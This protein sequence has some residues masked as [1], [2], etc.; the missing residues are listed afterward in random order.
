MNRALSIIV[1]GAVASG[2]ATT[3]SLQYDHSRCYRESMAHQSN[4]SRPTSIGAASRCPG[5]APV[6]IGGWL[7]LSMGV[8]CG[9]VVRH[10]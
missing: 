9:R 1:F 10:E 6:L 8:V 4:L 3:D 7:P 2:C 5:Y